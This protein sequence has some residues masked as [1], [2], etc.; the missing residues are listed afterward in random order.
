MLVSVFFLFDGFLLFDFFFLI[1]FLSVVIM[2]VFFLV[3]LLV[4]L[5]V[6][7]MGVGLLFFVVLFLVLGFKVFLFCFWNEVENMFVFW[8]VVLIEICMLDIL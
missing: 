2:I 1:V 4:V 6:D 7:K 3:F 8:V 5:R